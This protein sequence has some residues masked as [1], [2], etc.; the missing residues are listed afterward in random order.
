M[1]KAVNAGTTL[2][3]VIDDLLENY[4]KIPAYNP[5]QKRTVLQFGAEQYE[6]K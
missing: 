6:L 4:G 3:K 1:K 2:S 5:A